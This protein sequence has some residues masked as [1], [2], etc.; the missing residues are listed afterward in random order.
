MKR[1]AVGGI[2]HETNILA[3]VLTTRESFEQRSYY[4][5]EQML[6]EYAD[7]TASVA[8]LLAGVTESGYEPV[9]LLYAAAT[10][11]GPVTRDAFDFLLDSLLDR[12]KKAL[13]VDAVALA[14]HG[15]MFAEG[16][17][18]CEGV[19][20]RKVR[21]LVG[22]E[23]P[24]V[25]VLDFHANISPEM[26]NES[27]A[28]FCY[29]NNPHSDTFQKGKEAA[30]FL[31]QIFERNK[32]PFKY[33]Q[34]LPL[35]LSPLGNWTSANPFVSIRKAVAEWRAN[36]GIAAVTT[37]GGFAYARN[38]ACVS[39]LVYGWQEDLAK[40]AAQ[41]L[42]KMIWQGRQ[43]AMYKGIS[44]DTALTFALFS[45]E[46]TVVLSDLGDNVGGGS[47]GDNTQILERIIAL[48]IKGA[49]LTVCDPEAA[50]ATGTH[51]SGYV[52]GKI[53]PDKPVFIEGEITGRSDGAFLL[54]KGNHVSGLSGQHMSMGPSIVVSFGGNTLLIMSRPTPIGGPEPF[55]HMGLDP[56]DYKI[57]SIKAGVAF[58]GAYKYVSSLM[59]DVD[60]NGS[61]TCDL[62]SFIS[63][64]DIYPFNP[65]V[66]FD[67][68]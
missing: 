34:K 42:A 4:T 41:D 50:A 38:D 31:K 23:I 5:G 18:D 59:L 15:A 45:P 25:A 9:P 40:K 32:R 24:V 53:E 35:I 63:S 33:F 14:L 22:K 62:H 44:V 43:A 16:T 37:S 6:E 57:V 51:F 46:K 39:T 68:S 28:L 67:P 54:E 66:S 12:L 13:P 56:R 47:L 30:L 61:T 65:A 52:G 21:A 48:G 17:D 58:R 8:G 2:M 29:D 49:L 1:I 3:K 55:L 7:S 60:T 11:C 27:D 36:P 64:A 20:L 26:V 10:P 19:I